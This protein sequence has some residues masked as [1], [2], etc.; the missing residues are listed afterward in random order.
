M[1]GCLTASVLFDLT[2]TVYVHSFS[3][4]KVFDSLEKHE[5]QA[6]LNTSVIDQ[7]GR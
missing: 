3:Y 4:V 7:M 1:G 2:F 6:T 5:N